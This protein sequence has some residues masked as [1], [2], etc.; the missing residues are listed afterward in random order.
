MKLTALLSIVA[1]ASSASIANAADVIKA[2]PVSAPVFN[3]AGPYI[4]IEAGTA[5]SHF[6]STDKTNTVDELKAELGKPENAALAGVFAGYN[7]RLGQHAIFGIDG[8]VDF[9]S[10]NALRISES[11]ENDYWLY[12]E[13]ALAAARLRVG[14]AAGRFMPYL[15]GGLSI[16]RA[17]FAYGGTDQ[18]IISGNQLQDNHIGWNIGA[19]VDY[20]IAN[21]IFLR[22]D[23]RFSQNKIKHRY[24]FIN[25]NWT[26]EPNNIGIKSHQLRLGAAY[27]F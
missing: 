5:F 21:N 14:L 8:N 6:Y 19:G 20:A 25:E 7:F 26:K 17:A 22:A 16:A 10:S 9:H 15:A 3:W 2:R 24:E 13:T 11:G 1:I 18:G 27:K 4:G 23:Y 12:K